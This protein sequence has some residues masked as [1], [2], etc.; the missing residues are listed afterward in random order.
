[1]KFTAFRTSAAYDKWLWMIRTTA[2]IGEAEMIKDLFG[3][4]EYDFG[5]KGDEFWMV[6]L[7]SY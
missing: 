2:K 1:M 4:R 5:S 7:G 6:S 3:E